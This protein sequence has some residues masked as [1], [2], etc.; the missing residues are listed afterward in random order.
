[1]TADAGD[2]STDLLDALYYGHLHGGARLRK[3]FSGEVLLQ[4]WLDAEAALAH[5]Q[6]R[7]G[8]IPQE[9]ARMIERCARADRFDQR[10][11][12][13]EI[14]RRMH[15][16]VPVVEALGRAAG[17]AA[18]GYVHW[19]AT[20][21][22]IMDTA[23]VLQLRD[24]APVVD[25][26][27]AAFE[28]ALAE[29]ARAHRDT[30]MAGRTHGQHAVPITFGLK[31]AVWLDEWR[32][33]RDRFAQ[34]LPRVL[35]G[36]LGGAAGTLATM[37]EHGPVVR[38]L[39]MERLGLGDPTVAWHTA[40]DRIAE[41]CAALAFLAGTCGKI[42]REVIALQKDEGSATWGRGR[43]SGATYRT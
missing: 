7:V 23:S 5:A 27:A 9:A 37:P 13:D 17:T 6:A 41:W 43:R 29:L 16:L 21:Q 20:T 42:A 39:M 18:G 1:M 22:D 8:L 40:R 11:L 3:I 33:N 24:A 19:G 2:G 32:R 31:V 34:C 30:P 15:P 14:A 26:A 36:Q 25:A 10:A 4:R 35:T 28:S 38:R 12:G